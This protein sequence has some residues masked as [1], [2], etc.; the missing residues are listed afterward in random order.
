MA[1]FHRL[2]GKDAAL[3]ALR[4]RPIPGFL[5]A[6]LRYRG[7]FEVHGFGDV[8]FR[9]HSEGHFIENDLFWNGLEHSWEAGSVAQWVEWSRAAE[10]VLDVG[11]N[12]GVYALAAQAAN[13]RAL[14]L[15]FEPLERTHRR[16]Q[17]NISL[18]RFPIDARMIAIGDSDG[19]AQLHDM[20][21][22]FG[23][24]TS[25]SLNPDFKRSDRTVE[26][27]LRRLDSLLD[28]LNVARI[29]L[30]KI[31]VET[32][33]PQVLRG[34]GARLATDRPVI[35]VEILS[36]EAGRE[37]ESILDGLDY[38]WFSI[39]EI[40]GPVAESNIRAGEAPNYLLVPATRQRPAAHG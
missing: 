32:L 15:A 16:L 22:P 38:E 23:D 7:E 36:D 4:E 20:D 19:T 14:V 33:E 10:C 6:V 37:I 24:F 21:R 3:R 13:P 40:A 39:D 27:V 12:V 5:S 26:I 25:A 31:D 18:N 34:L 1:L 30:V 11:A 2:P 8:C 35:L 17:R 29:D 28:E 9:M